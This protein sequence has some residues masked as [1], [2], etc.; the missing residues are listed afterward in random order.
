[1]TTNPHSLLHRLRSWRARRAEL[2]LIRQIMLGI[3]VVTPV[4]LGMYL[5]VLI[6]GIVVQSSTYLAY[7]FEFA[8]KLLVQL[9]AIL[10]FNFPFI[11]M[12]GTML[13]LGRMAEH[14][15][16]SAIRF[17]G[18][19]VYRITGVIAMT[20][21][22][23]AGVM[24]A[25]KEHVVTH[26]NSIIREHK[27]NKQILSRSRHGPYHW[28]RFDGVL[29]GFAVTKQQIGYYRDV[30]IL[31]FAQPDR[32]DEVM[33]AEQAEYFPSN[34][35]DKKWRL[36]H[37][38][39]DD[40]T[41]DSSAYYPVLWRDEFLSANGGNW[42]GYQASELRLGNLDRTGCERR[43]DQSA[44]TRAYCFEFWHR[45]AHP[46]LL[47]SLMLF[48]SSF[49]YG[50]SRVYPVSARMMGGLAVSAAFIGLGNSIPYLSK[51]TDLPYSVL[52]IAPALLLLLISVFRI[53]RIARRQ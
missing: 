1:M 45:L 52:Y 32:L 48:A 7:T 5:L 15:E 14:G 10:Q 13:G 3:A 31:R 42:L 4:V 38:R 35:D 36:T 51:S 28:R 24:F 12:L 26:A 43:Q 30:M 50:L 8:W 19:G 20:A 16:I 46:L 2:Y 41:R 40:Y 34:P 27:D 53:L 22:L 11:A 25:F 37:V 9:P 33:R 21:I 6:P 17:A 23:L 18:V 49:I 29:A 47:V 44:D 39:I